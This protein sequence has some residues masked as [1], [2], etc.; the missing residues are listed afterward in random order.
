MVRS[1]H[2]ISIHLAHRASLGAEQVLQPQLLLLES[3]LE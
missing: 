2:Q 1:R 3:Y